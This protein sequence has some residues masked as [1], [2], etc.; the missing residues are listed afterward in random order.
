MVNWVACMK[1][2]RGA[3]KMI[4]PL[5]AMVQ[6]KGEELTYQLGKLKDAQ[7]ELARVKQNVAELQADLAKYQALADEKGEVLDEYQKKLR[8]AKN[9]ID[10]LEI[11]RVRW[12]KD[13]NN[14]NNLKIRLIGDVGI[15]C[16]FLA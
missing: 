6:E 7:E 16:A 12:E 1:K 5:M 11:N 15:S 8:A 13:K 14:Y 9:L 10:S 3:Y 4:A 2:F